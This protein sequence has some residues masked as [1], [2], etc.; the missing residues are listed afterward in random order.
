[1]IFM[2]YLTRNGR[3]EYGIFSMKEIDE[4]DRY[5]AAYAVNTKRDRFCQTEFI[6]DRNMET[7]YD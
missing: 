7:L 4:L 5:K 3:G 2:G 6:I 1:M